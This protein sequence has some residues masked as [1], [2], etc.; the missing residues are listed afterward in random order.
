MCKIILHED[1]KR[2][3]HSMLFT[4]THKNQVFYFKTRGKKKTKPGKVGIDQIHPQMFCK[5]ITATQFC[6][7]TLSV[8]THTHNIHNVDLQFIGDRYL[9]ILSLCKK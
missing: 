1:N 8:H 3:I 9:R 4:S 6:H 2:V 5:T 7:R